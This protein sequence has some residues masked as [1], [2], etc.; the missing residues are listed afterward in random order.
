VTVAVGLLTSL[1][2][3][4]VTEEFQWTY[5]L[6]DPCVA[7]IG[8][9][10]KVVLSSQTVNTPP[11]V[12]PVHPTCIESSVQVSPATAVHTVADAAAVTLAFA[13]LF[14]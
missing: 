3:E 11:T 12:P 13:C 5:R 1:S 14:L 10:R 8:I 9:R 7:D 2:E 6:T 4:F